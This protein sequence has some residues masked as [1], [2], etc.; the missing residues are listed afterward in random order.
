MN[1]QNLPLSA[2]TKP[3]LSTSSPL[4]KKVAEKAFNPSKANKT[5]SADE[6]QDILK[7]STNN[8]KVEPE[9]KIALKEH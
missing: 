3:K 9:E 2:L 6:I 1:Q 8:L 4:M 5:F 7:R